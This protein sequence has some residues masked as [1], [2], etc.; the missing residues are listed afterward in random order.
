MD[1]SIFHIDTNFLKKV[2]GM[3]FC[4]YEEQWLLFEEL[5]KKKIKN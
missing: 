2:W 5:C 4:A 1:S 3:G